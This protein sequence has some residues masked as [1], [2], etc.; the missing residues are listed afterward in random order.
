MSLLLLHLTAQYMQYTTLAGWLPTYG[1]S[2]QNTY[3]IVFCSEPKNAVFRP[4]A[5]ARTTIAR[6]GGK[7]SGEAGGTEQR[8]IPTKNVSR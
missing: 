3:F 4:V 6:N 7:K 5:E 2:I 1:E 8:A